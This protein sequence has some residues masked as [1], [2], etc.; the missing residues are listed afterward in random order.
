MFSLQMHIAL[1]SP[2]G[3]RLSLVQHLVAVAVV[4]A[5]RKQPGCHVSQSDLILKLNS[6]RFISFL[7]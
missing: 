1:D 5:I 6:T 2:L 7:N 4:G 3:S